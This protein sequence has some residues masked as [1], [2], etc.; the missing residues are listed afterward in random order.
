MIEPAGCSVAESMENSLDFMF[1]MDVAR[2]VAAQSIMGLAY[3]HSNGICHGGIHVHNF[4]SS[5]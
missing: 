3:M 4:W 5:D 2:T 1:S